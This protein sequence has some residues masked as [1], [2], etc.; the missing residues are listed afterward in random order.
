MTVAPH[1]IPN[2]FG[3]GPRFG[4]GGRF[5]GRFWGV[6]GRAAHHLREARR[7]LAGD[8]N[9]DFPNAVPRF[10]ER[11][12]DDRLAEQAAY[13]LDP[14]AELGAD[15]AWLKSVRTDA[16][17]ASRALD[18]ALGP[19]LGRYIDRQ[20]G[21]DAGVRR[22]LLHGELSIEQAESM[23]AEHFQDAEYRRVERQRKS[24]ADK[25]FKKQPTNCFVCGRLKRRP[26]D[27]CPYCGDDPVQ[28]GSARSDF[29][30][31]YGYAG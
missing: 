8:R 26:S 12:H 21:K 6:G 18:V 17:T 28:H 11:A 19:E 1:D 22:R 25:G 10:T 7:G 16:R 4:I 3:R 20:W 31:A 29:D 5:H 23:A 27:V 24:L 2:S 15:E 9:H 30:R 13:A 14:G